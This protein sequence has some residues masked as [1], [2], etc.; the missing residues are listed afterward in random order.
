MKVIVTS[1]QHLGYDKSD[2]TSFSKFLDNLASD[3]AP[4]DFVLLGDVVDMWRR[5]A[6]GVFLE[7]HDILE[8]ILGLTA[9]MNVYFVAGNHDYHVLRLVNKPGRF[10]PIMFYPIPP[11]PD[12]VLHDGN[13]QYLFKHG[14][15]Y[16]EEQQP[17]IMEAMCRAMSDETGDIESNIWNI[18]THESGFL[19]ELKSVANRERRKQQIHHLQLRPEERLTDFLLRRVEQ[20]ACNDVK[21]NQVVVFGHTHVPFVNKKENVANTGSWVTDAPADY[22]TYVELSNGKPRL[23]VFGGQEITTRKDLC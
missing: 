16:D 9:K 18:L 1:D 20:K 15:E 8:K 2:R 5:D 4:T 11:S 3:L 17:P 19:E 13:Y 23:F 10:Y 6:S 14:W 7:S 21:A 22:D 12:L